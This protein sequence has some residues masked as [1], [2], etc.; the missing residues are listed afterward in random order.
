[1]VKPSSPC[2]GGH[3]G[4]EVHLQQQVAELLAQVRVVA[5]ARSPR[6][7][8]RSP[9]AGTAPA[10]RASARG[11]RGTRCAAGP[12]PSPGPAAARPARRTTRA[13]PRRGR[14]SP[15]RSTASASSGRQLVR[16]GVGGQPHHVVGAR[17]PR[18]RRDQPAPWRGR[19][20]RP[21]ARRR[22][23]R[24][25]AAR[26]PRRRAGGTP[27]RPRR[28]AGP[29]HQPG[30]DPRAGDQEG[31][32]HF[33]LAGSEETHEAGGCGW[34]RRRRLADTGVDSEPL[35]G[36]SAPLTKWP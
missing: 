17:R 7:S 3:P 27:R 2:L 13:A 12:S 16:L 4:V 25:P 6:G 30:G 28:H 29:G 11:P 20:S 19:L 34:R 26:P 32:P 36:R 31:Q 10:S 5:R 33:W 23:P 35:S 1:M 14:P 15:P 21:G 9:P 24:G 8:R 18:A 22:R